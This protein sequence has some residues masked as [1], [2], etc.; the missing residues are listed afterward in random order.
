MN[1]FWV[2]RRRKGRSSRTNRNA[3]LITRAGLT[4]SLTQL[5]LF[6]ITPREKS[7]PYF[8]INWS[9]RTCSSGKKKCR[10]Q[11]WSFEM[12]FM[13][14]IARGSARVEVGMYMWSYLR[15]GGCNIMLC[16]WYAQGM[17]MEFAWWFV[18]CN[19]RIYAWVWDF[20]RIN[21][22]YGFNMQWKRRTCI[23]AWEYGE[24]IIGGGKAY[25]M[26]LENEI[27]AA[28]YLWARS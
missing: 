11:Y 19:R 26:L 10:Y 9:R 14:Y 17:R 12:L 24:R 22:K 21:V 5:S 8:C 27:L 3:P 1:T 15:N 16:M 7:R 20:G 13:T 6:S 2:G 28:T 18:L 25:G 23:Q 4:L